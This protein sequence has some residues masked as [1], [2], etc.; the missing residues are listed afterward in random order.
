MKLPIVELIIVYLLILNG[1]LLVSAI[2][3]KMNEIEENRA[4]IEKAEES[5]NILKVIEKLGKE[6]D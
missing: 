6:N 2:P 1:K 3:F 4:K 5:E